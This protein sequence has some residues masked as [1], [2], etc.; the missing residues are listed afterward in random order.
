M[1]AASLEALKVTLWPP[2]NM[3][4]FKFIFEFIFLISN[5]FMANHRE[6]ITNNTPK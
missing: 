4:L 6:H 1:W 3:G 2:H 5:M